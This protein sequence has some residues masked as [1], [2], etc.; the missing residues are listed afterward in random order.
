MKKRIKKTEELLLRFFFLFLLSVV[1]SAVFAQEDVTSTYLVNA[2]F[3]GAYAVYEEQPKTDRAIYQPEGWSVDWTA[4]GDDLTAITGG[5]LYANLVSDSFTMTDTE[6]RGQ[7]TYWTRFKYIN[8]SSPRFRLYQQVSLLKGKYRLSV[9]MLQYNEGGAANSALLFAGVNTETCPSSSVKSDEAGWNHLE[10]VFSLSDEQTVDLG[11]S[12]VHTVGGKEQIVG[13]DNFKLEYLG[14]PDEAEP[15]TFTSKYLVNPSFEYIAEGTPWTATWRGDPWGWTRSGELIGNSFGISNDASDFDGNAICWYRSVPM[16]EFFEMSQ[17]VEG[18]P[19]GK[20]VVSC[21]LACF[22]N[23]ISNQRLFANNYAQYYA[24]EAY[25]SENLGEETHKTFAGHAAIADATKC[26]LQPM[27]VE[28]LLYEGESLTLGIRSGD[29]MADGSHSAAGAGWFKVDDFQ[30]DYQGYDVNDYLNFLQ[31]YIDEAEELLTK[32]ISDEAREDLTAKLADAKL[33]DENSANADIKVA[34]DNLAAAV[35]AAKATVSDDDDPGELEKGIGLIMDMVHHNPGD[36]QYDSRYNDP[37]TL[38]QMGYNAK[39]FYLFDSP[40]LAINWDSYDPNVLPV[41]S[42]DRAWVEAKAARL[43]T[44]YDECKENN[45]DVF[46]MCDLVLLPKRLVALKGISS[47]YGDATNETTQDLL[48]YQ[49]QQSFAQFPQLDGLVVRIGETY[50]QDAPYHQGNIQ[51]KTDADRCIIP[52]MQ[53]LREEICVKLNKRLVFRT[54]MSFDENPTLYNYVSNSVEPH[55]NLYIGVKHC[56]G[57]FHRGNDFSDVLATGRHQQIVEVQCAREYEGKGAF[58]NYVARGVIDGFEEHESMGAEG[59]VWNLRDVYESGR[60][61]GVWTWTRGG[62]WEGPYIKDEL[63]CDLNAWVMAQWAHHPESSEDSLFNAYCTE[64][65]KL[66]EANTALFREIAMLSEHAV[67]RGMRSA[68]YPGSVYSMWVRD[69]YITFP[70]M[71]ADRNITATILDEREDAVADWEQIVEKAQQFN[72]ADA[73]LNEVVKVSCEYGLQM[74]R[75]FRSVGQVAA[76]YQNRAD[77][78]MI[79]YFIDYFDAWK[80]LDQLLADYPETCSTLFNRQTVLRTTSTVAHT[81]MEKLS[82]GDFDE[83]KAVIKNAIDNAVIGENTGQTSQEAVDK[84]KQVYDQYAEVTTGNTDEEVTEAYKAL[85]EAYDDYLTN[86]KVPGGAPIQAMYEDLTVEKLVEAS[87]FSRADTSVTTRFATPAN[88]TVENFRIPNGGDGTKNGIDR[89]PGYDCLYLG[90]WNDKQN[91]EE[92]DISNARIYRLVHLKPGRYYFGVAYN[93]TYSLNDEAYIFASSELVTTDEIPVKAMAHY[94]INEA[95][96]N[97]SNNLYGLFFTIDEEQDVYLGWQANLDNGSNTQEF[98]AKTVALY[99]YGQISLESLGDLIN[100]VEEAIPTYVVNDNTG[101]YSQESVD[102]LKTLVEE[103]KKVDESSSMDELNNAY[104]ELLNVYNNFTEDGRN[105]GSA[106]TGVEGEDYAD[107]TIEKLQESG[108]FKRTDD[109]LD[110][111]RFGAPE[112][113]I[114]ENFGFGSEAGIDNISGSDCL[115]LEVWWNNAAYAENGYDISNVRLY[116]KVTLPAGTYYFGASYP[117]AEANEDLYIFASTS[118]LNTSDIPS[119]AIAFEKV[120]KAAADGSFRGIFF[121]LEEETEVYL[122]FQADF[123]NVNTNNLRC[124][125]VKLLQYGGDAVSVE[126]LRADRTKTVDWT[127]PYQVF[128]LSGQQLPSI[129]KR[130]MVVVRQGETVVKLLCK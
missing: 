79:P 52:L 105:Q 66:D 100:Q 48:R 129:P 60:L 11:F 115:H 102:A 91:N 109:T 88:W 9:N 62:G 28:I 29:L 61:S 33:I 63:W 46:A 32:N 69:E 34:T 18:L 4:N 125:G 24:S 50:L 43:N 75:I 45:I 74:F 98:R 107:I 30:L 113:W 14:E 112:Y 119:Q 13:A 128:S 55:K 40:T 99:Y 44:L 86:G 121:T 103:A 89:Y 124:S 12:V 90:L 92:G 108:P 21:R 3:E 6:S 126:S 71:P 25:Y 2:D 78:D 81:M 53:L 22:S 97:N 36:A 31:T 95:P 15:E 127:A 35:E 117:S 8:I 10:V 26:P 101:Y 42:E 54:W 80:K 87:G 65:L 106:P 96:D 1:P 111:G 76:I 67:I 83:L 123:S 64:R 77:G 68:E 94:K 120:N 58:P 5:D 49:I 19:A 114:V 51:N 85:S 84:L 104:N 17:T 16:P 56:E 47:T 39:C 70:D 72:S 82:H 7:K 116:Q 23:L 110:T 20:Y 38:A 37:A 27:S 57:D 59:K 93:T 118:L 41:G 122:G 130:G 73:H